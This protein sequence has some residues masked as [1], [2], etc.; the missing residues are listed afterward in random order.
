M[1]LQVIRNNLA[2]V[3]A[4]AIV[5]PANP[6]AEIG[7]GTESSIY[8][9]AGV[10]KLLAARKKI[11]DLQ[12]GEVAATP[13]FNLRAKIIIHAVSAV[14]S[15]GDG[16][17]TKI[18]RDCYRK[19]LELAREMNCRSIAFP[20]L[21]TGTNRVPKEKSLL[22]AV[23]T[24][25]KFLST[26]EMDVTLVI[27]GQR[28]FELVENFF[29]E[30]I[31]VTDEHAEKEILQREYSERRRRLP[32]GYYPNEHFPQRER[33]QQITLPNNF[34]AEYAD[35]TIL[36]DVLS[37]WGQDFKAELNRLVENFFDGKKMS[38]SD[39]CLQANLERK[40][41]YDA[42]AFTKHRPKK[43]ILFAMIFA[44]ELS[45]PD[46]LKL[47]A[48]AE[49]FLSSTDPTDLVVGDFLRKKIFD[50]YEV[51]AALEEKNLEPLG[52]K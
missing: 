19:S 34:F 30:I 29:D 39:F 1:S 49:Y 2:R 24:I 14:W 44:L 35:E 52:S 8:E 27:F 45:L 18:L 50:V 22:A 26:N 40:V 31:S 9:A 33:P 41:F 3:E 12:P 32:D 42:I 28:T 25:E 36:R 4:D 20:L 5:I 17:E 51:N 16:D 21:G 15:G 38:K 10:E 13:A 43:K 7:G 6:P 23:V 48:R 47:L 46:A 37:V 11:G